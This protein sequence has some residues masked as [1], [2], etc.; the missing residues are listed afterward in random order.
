M[1]MMAKASPESAGRAAAEE[2][3][4]HL[5]VVDVGRAA[6]VAV[7]QVLA[8]VVPQPLAA[9]GEHAVRLADVLEAPLGLLAVLLRGAGVTVCG[10]GR[11][12]DTLTRWR[13]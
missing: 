4:E 7:L 6:A 10:K 8:V 3:L 11:G 1:M 13:E 2:R 12:G 5:A 9:V